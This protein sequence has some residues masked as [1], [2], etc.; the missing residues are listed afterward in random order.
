MTELKEY[1]SGTAGECP[2]AGGAGKPGEASA[3]EGC[4]ARAACAAG[5]T[6]YYS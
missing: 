6:F 3:C 4:P 5:H 2:S 1:R